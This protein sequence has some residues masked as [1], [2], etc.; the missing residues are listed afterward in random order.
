VF[1]VGKMKSTT[2]AKDITIV[3]YT[4]NFLDEV[5]PYFLENTKKQL[6]KAADGLPI[7]IV[8]QKPTLF[9]DNSIN[10]CLGN[11]G[12][13]HLNIYRQILEGCKAAKTEYVAM[14]EDDILYSWEHFH[15]K[16][17]LKDVF[18]YDMNKI[19]LFTWTKP[20]M[21]SF[22]HNRMVVNQLIAKREMLIEA[23]EE[24]FAKFP[25]ESK[26]PLKHWG[27]PGRYENY[28]GVTVRETDQFMSTCPS[29]VFSHEH[30]YG[31]L[32]QGRKKRLGD[33]RII[34]VPYWGRAED[35]LKRFYE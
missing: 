13:S 22:R 16:V 8:S 17:P 3:Y 7:V 12:R 32:N 26:V 9:G 29:I 18:L 24:R 5:N 33:L 15:S 20:P 34:E 2:N 35:V 6:L 23:M 27:D 31:Y 1:L 19:S 28:L 30:A 10:V 4:S 14:A 25:D 11:I 21:F